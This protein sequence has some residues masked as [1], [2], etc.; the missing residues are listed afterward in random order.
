M[1]AYEQKVEIPEKHYQYLVV[2][3]DPYENI[4]FKI[5]NMEI[6]KEDNRFKVIWDAQLKKYY[7]NI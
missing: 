6:D 1:G 7:I 5:P 4:A 2:A 3:G